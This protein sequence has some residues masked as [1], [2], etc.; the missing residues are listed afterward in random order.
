MGAPIMAAVESGGG[1]SHLAD[2]G[3]EVA[4]VEQRVL[5]VTHSGRVFGGFL[6]GE[7]SPL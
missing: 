7:G 3:G 5:G 2:H 6:V 1:V 4:P